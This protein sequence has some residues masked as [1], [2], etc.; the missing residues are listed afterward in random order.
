MGRKTD[1]EFGIK[2]EANLH[3][4]IIGEKKREKQRQTDADRQIYI[5]ICMLGL[6][7][8]ERN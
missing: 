1:N 8:N 3:I 6:R 5:K 7:R 4:W 2:E